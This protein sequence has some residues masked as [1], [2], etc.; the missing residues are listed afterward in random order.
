MVADDGESNLNSVDGLGEMGQFE[1]RRRCGPGGKTSRT[2][3]RSSLFGATA[4]TEV[5]ARLRIV[6]SEIGFTQSEKDH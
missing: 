3:A 1:A 4:Q 2:A 6:S 5:L